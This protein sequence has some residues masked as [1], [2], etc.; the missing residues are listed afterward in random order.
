[1]SSCAEREARQHNVNL[2]TVTGINLKTPE[3]IKKLTGNGVED[4]IVAFV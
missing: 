3:L 1:M 4:S 2:G